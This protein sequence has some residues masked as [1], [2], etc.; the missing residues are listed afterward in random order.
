MRLGLGA[1]A[2]AAG[3]L[4]TLTGCETKVGQ[5]S[6]VCR[7]GSQVAEP[8]RWQYTSKVDPT[9][10]QRIPRAIDVTLHYTGDAPRSVPPI[11]TYF[12]REGGAVL[13]VASSA[14]ATMPAK[15]TFTYHVDTGGYAQALVSTGTGGPD[16]LVF[17]VVVDGFRFGGLM[18]PPTCGQWADGHLDVGLA[19]RLP[20]LKDRHPLDMA[21]AEWLTFV[22]LPPAISR[23]EGPE[24]STYAYF[25]APVALTDAKN[26]TAA[27]DGPTKQEAEIGVTA[28]TPLFTLT[29]EPAP[30][31]NNP[32]NAP[33]GGKT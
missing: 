25:K 26:E 18:S 4:V 32:A 20:D 2:V 3:M 17:F 30:T 24:V 13:R 23:T 19:T 15:G 27:P 7:P 11:T 8:V 21:Q 1:L 28:T 16:A 12:Y 33:Q 10:L 9:V 31:G 22:P 29:Q 6:V 14:E 5:I